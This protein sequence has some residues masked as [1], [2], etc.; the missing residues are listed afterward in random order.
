M[1][2]II[3]A[4]PY[5]QHSH[6]NRQMLER[7]KALPGVEIR[8]LYELYP[9]FNIDIAAEQQ[10]LS[11]ADLVI[12]QHPMQW[13][14]VPPLMKLWIDK[15]LSHGWA[16]GKG[17]NALHGKEVMWAVTTGGSEKHFELGDHPGFDVLAQ[18]LQATALYCGMQWL[19]AFAIHF[20]FV[21]DELTLARQ[22]DDYKQRLIDWQEAHRG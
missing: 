5:P 7:A 6:A 19:P 22:A 16:Y 15:V 3:Y 20:T 1:I 11:R 13:Y 18:P 12:W 14:S 17:G 10:A 4:H 21:C 2:L 9:D 8:S